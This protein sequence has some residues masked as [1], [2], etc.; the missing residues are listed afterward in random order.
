MSRNKGGAASGTGAATTDDGFP[1]SVINSRWLLVLA[2]S[3]LVTFGS[4]T[5]PF[6]PHY[7]LLAAIIAS[8]A[9]LSLLRRRFAGFN[10]AVGVVTITDV[11][12]VSLIIA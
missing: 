4:R 3:A 7:S 2:I 10:Q 1:S 6:L 9:S 11:I 12:M 5:G 8:N